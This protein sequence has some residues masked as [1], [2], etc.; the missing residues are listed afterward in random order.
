MKVLYVCSGNL[1][2]ISPF[3]Q[4][5]TDS[6]KRKGIE[7]DFF[8]ICGKG[9]LG[10]L[11]NLKNYNKKVKKFKPD[12]IHAHYGLSGLFANFQFKIPT[13][14]TFH[15][16]DINFKKNR[17]LSL[18]AHLFSTYSI[19]VSDK[20]AAKIKPKDRFAIIPCGID[21][22]VFYPMPVNKARESV[23]FNSDEKVI[24]F[25]NAFDNEVKNYPLA[26]HA[27]ELLKINIRFVELKGC[28][29]KKVN[30]L[31]NSCDVALMTSLSE[32]S[33]QFIKEA[34]ACNCP[35]VSTDVGD[36]KSILSGVEG[37]FIST[38]E[39]QDVANT[40]K[41]ALSFKRRT[42]GRDKV[43]HLSN[44]LL[45]QQIVDIYLKIANK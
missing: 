32:G 9:L 11:K 35:I 8:F 14:T 31:L 45:A 29:R 25:S 24:L 3:I 41:R 16:S 44:E 36:V 34:M 30:E 2:K 22:D 21:F 7:I 38:Y 6:I 28:S 15:G 18:F 23:G 42:N 12:L 20:I 13:I 37:C 19:F 39:T 26:K 43:K 33:P 17:T 5:Q 40:I 10:Y 27:I 4:E 1:N